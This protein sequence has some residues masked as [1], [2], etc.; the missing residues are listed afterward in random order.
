MESYGKAREDFFNGSIY[1]KQTVDDRRSGKVARDEAAKDA[2]EEALIREAE[3]FSSKI[4]REAL[5]KAEDDNEPSLEEHIEM[6]KKY[7]TPGTG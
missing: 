7:N 1:A 6:M 3:A 2:R 5:A 4:A